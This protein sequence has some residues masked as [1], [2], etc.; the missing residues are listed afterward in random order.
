[1]EYGINMLELLFV[2]NWLLIRNS[3]DEEVLMRRDL[4]GNRML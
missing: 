1:M 2:V 4:L 3:V